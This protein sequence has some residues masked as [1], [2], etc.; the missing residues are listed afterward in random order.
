VDGLTAPRR[1]QPSGSCGGR[2]MAQA[3]L[4]SAPELSGQCRGLRYDRH[5]PCEAW[6]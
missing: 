1:P 4:T 3:Q 5:A 2:A 6:L